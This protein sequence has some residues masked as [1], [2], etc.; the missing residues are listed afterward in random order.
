MFPPSFARRAVVET[1]RPGE[2]VFDPFCGRGTT[3]LEALLNGRD[4]IASDINPVAA[5]IS[6]AKAQPPTLQKVLSRLEALEARFRAG[7]GS[8][9]SRERERLPIFFHYA[10][11]PSTLEQILYLR[12]LLRWR[13][14]RTDRFIAALLLGHLHGESNRSPNYLSNHM[15]H[16]I[17]LKPRYAIRY[18]KERGMT[19]PVRD[20]FAIL[21]GRALFRFANGVPPRT[22]RVVCADARCSARYFRVYEGQVAAV[23]TSPPYLNVT[24]YEE[25]QWLRLWFL[26]GPPR[27][28]YRAISRDDRHT[29]PDRYFQFLAE[30]WRGIAP[31]VRSHAYLVCR[32]GSKSLAR[33][34][35]SE[36]LIHSVRAAWPRC[37]LVGPPR[38]SELR[39]RQTNVFRPGS[40]GC[41]YEY[42]FR[43]IL[44]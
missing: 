29:S 11:A 41:R 15:P 4:A 8:A 31:L 5:L 16:T 2:L 12:N 39:N 22:G 36:R 3:V 33:D 42:D 38:A 44:L 10:F 13:R 6:R 17:A 7:V 18:W 24:N 21:R 27:P 25:D 14:S 23:I 26:G 40:V 19:A 43:F 28:T 1:T 20:V 30:A 35:V 34:E 32:I 37:R 9:Y